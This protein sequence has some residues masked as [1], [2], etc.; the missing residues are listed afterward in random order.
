MKLERLDSGCHGNEIA[1]SHAANCSATWASENSF[2]TFPDAK[3]S[4]MNSFLALTTTVNI[5]EEPQVKAN[6]LSKLIFM[7]WCTGF[8]NNVY[9][10]R[11]F[12][13]Y[14]TRWPLPCI[15]FSNRNS[16][17]P[18]GMLDTRTP[19][20]REVFRCW[21]VIWFSVTKTGSWWQGNDSRM[22]TLWKEVGRREVLAWYLS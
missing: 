11:N 7:T 3:I 10:E 8:I 4:D 16:G 19:M 21:H 9:L 20:G 2:W 22:H 14:I 6:T 1:S 18:S 5:E 12:K 15:L 17:S 13:M